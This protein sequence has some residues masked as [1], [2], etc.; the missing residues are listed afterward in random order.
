M[1]MPE[2]DQYLDEAADT[3]EDDDRYAEGEQERGRYAESMDSPKHDERYAEGERERGR[4]G[5]S[6]G[7]DHD[8]SYAAGSGHGTGADSASTTALVEGSGELFERWQRVQSAFV[9]APRD[10]VHEAGAIVEDVLGR[11]SR[12]FN[13]ERRRLDQAWDAGE[14]PSTEELRIALRRYRE[15]FERLLAA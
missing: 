7:R 9:D 8:E 4:Y 1:N 3:R 15:F 11:L 14:E 13:D 5:D 10:S 6:V 2:R 12:T